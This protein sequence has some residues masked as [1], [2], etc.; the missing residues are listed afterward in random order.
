MP[1]E[2]TASPAVD[3]VGAGPPGQVA[4]ADSQQPANLGAILFASLLAQK[5]Q[6]VPGKSR[7]SRNLEP[8]IALQKPT[9]LKG[10][11]ATAEQDKSQAQMP[12]PALAIW[13][14]LALLQNAPAPIA[15]SGAASQNAA[16]PAM[17]NSQNEVMDT[18]SRSAPISKSSESASGGLLPQAPA[19]E[20]A[21]APELLQASLPAREPVPQFDTAAQPDAA[22]Q[23][24]AAGLAQS[25][26]AGPVQSPLIAAALTPSADVSPPIPAGTALPTVTGDPLPLPVGGALPLSAAASPVDAPASMLPAVASM[27]TNS[28]DA[29]SDAP[30][31]AKTAQPPATTPAAESIAAPAVQAADVVGSPAPLPQIGLQ[32][33]APPA[34][35]TGRTVGGRLANAAPAVKSSATIAAVAVA[36]KSQSGIDA[37]LP[38]NPSAH[39]SKEANWDQPKDDDGFARDATASG[40]SPQPA[41]VAVL[42]GAVS[43]VVTGSD[44]AANSSVA[45]AVTLD[46]AQAGDVTRQIAENVS[47]IKPQVLAAGQ[48][49]MTVQ[50]HP[51]EWG[52]LRVTI[53]LAPSQSIDG[54]KQ[55]TVAAHIVASSPAVKG[56]LDDHASDLNQALRD[57]GLHLDRL[58]VAVQAAG[59]ASQSGAAASDG[60]NASSQNNQGQSP[61]PQPQGWNSGAAFGGGN[62]ASFA[63]FSQGNGGNAS[64]SQADPGNRYISPESNDVDSSPV[65]SRLASS[66][67]GF[68]RRA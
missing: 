36:D 48:G 57:I 10:K 53:S 61:A 31:V 7:S 35:N 54:V 51:K 18:V 11:T 41:N 46:T 60:Q 9:T 38:G 4:A 67:G 59:S 28:L 25:L 15:P 40:Q 12:D 13:A 20:S 5:A 14:A 34:N 33:I 62:M 3:A 45:S 27:P 58:T 66:Q 32:N 50:L 65:T 29:R 42:A 39:S 24:H 55:T 8:D 23:P 21:S 17:P 16:A 37:I 52:D 64:H 6:P 68:D 56:A 1:L 19:A 30:P 49:Q 63:A 44:Q 22:A 2:V 26:P 43:A 47:A